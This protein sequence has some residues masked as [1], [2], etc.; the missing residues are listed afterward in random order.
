MKKNPIQ[1][2]RR[3]TDTTKVIM[4]L[5]TTVAFYL[6]DN[7]VLKEDKCA[8]QNVQIPHSF[9][10]E[11]VDQKVNYLMSNPVRFEAKEND[12]LQRLI[13]EYV[14]EDFQLFVQNCCGI[15]GATSR[16]G[17]NE[18]GWQVLPSI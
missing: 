6:D 4:I 13:D 16:K 9:F 17:E 10:T 8:T 2:L 5:K 12:E 14:D 15:S 18:C 3:L 7:G 1:Q 11:L